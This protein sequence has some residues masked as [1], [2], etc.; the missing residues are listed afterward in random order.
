MGLIT[1]ENHVIGLGLANCKLS[2]L[3]ETFGNLQNLENL[4]LS[5]NKINV[6]PNPSPN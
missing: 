6:L 1:K 3:P 4:A 5:T 2:I